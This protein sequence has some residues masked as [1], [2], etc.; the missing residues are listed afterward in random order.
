MLFGKIGVWEVV[1]V[2]AI[3][4]LLFGSRRLPALGRGLGLGI[5]NFRDSLR[6]SNADDGR[7]GADDQQEQEQPVALQTNEQTRSGSKSGMS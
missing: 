4:F 5:S 3:V 2:L 1:I 6:S 7:A